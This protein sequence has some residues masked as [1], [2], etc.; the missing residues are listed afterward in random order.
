MNWHTDIPEND[1]DHLVGAAVFGDKFQAWNHVLARVNRREASLGALRASQNAAADDVQTGITFTFEAD[2]PTVDVEVTPLPDGRVKV[3]GPGM[4][5]IVLNTPDEVDQYLKGSLPPG[6]LVDGGD[7][8]SD[9]ELQKAGIPGPAF[10]D[11]GIVPEEEGV[12]REERKTS[13]GI[14]L[15][16]HGVMAGRSMQLFD[17]DLMIDEAAT[18]LSNSLGK[19]GSVA[20]PEHFVCT[21]ITATAVKDGHVVEGALD[22]NVRLHS[23]RYGK[24]QTV[25]VHLP[26]RHGRLMDPTRMTTS[27]GQ[28]VPMTKEAVTRLMEIPTGHTALPGLDAIRQDRLSFDPYI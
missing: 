24:G 5:E 27:S 16:D 10:Q 8:E 22:W 20:R 12:F 3:K 9:E 6:G 17:R 7:G 19:F 4:G 2:G 28:A 14:R 18:V 21:R 15:S 23:Y 26:I 11:E 25:G 13:G 1:A